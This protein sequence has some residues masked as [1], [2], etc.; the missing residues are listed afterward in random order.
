MLEAVIPDQVRALRTFARAGP[1]EDV[2]DV[3][4]VRGESRRGFG[5][6]RDALFVRWGREGRHPSFPSARSGR[7]LM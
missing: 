2:D 1:A 6:G 3:H 7:S 5:G 4:G